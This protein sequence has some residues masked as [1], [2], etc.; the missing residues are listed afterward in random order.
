MKKVKFI[1]NNKK[2]LN[3][4]ENALTLYKLMLVVNK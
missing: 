3:L 4:T 2:F 1:Y